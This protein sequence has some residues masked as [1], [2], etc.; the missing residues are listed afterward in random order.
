ML[1]FEQS[2]SV[3]P[4]C[5]II[6]GKYN[7]KVISID[8]D[9][10]EPDYVTS[11]K[12]LEIGN[13]SKLQMVPNTSS[14]RDVYY[15]TGPSGSG[16]SYFVRMYCEQYKKKFKNNEIYL[17]SNLKEDESLDS[18]KPKRVKLDDDLYN[19]PIKVDEF[20]DSCVIFDDTDC[21]S[22]KKIRNAVIAL[23]DQCLEVGRHFR[24]TVLIT[25]HLPSDRQA[26]RKMLN[27]CGYLVYFPQSS[28][29]K[30]K[31]VLTNYL[32]IEEKMIKYFKRLNSRWICIRKN[33]P[34]CWVSEHACALLNV[35][36][37]DE[38]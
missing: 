6:G 28:S 26:T 36:S 20:A 14:E 8:T 29:S 18:V 16:K 23:L 19:D 12:K 9:I 31:Y 15:I 11:F 25:F 32:D 4:L 22:D 2:K 13:S 1:T 37:E 33:F 38:K 30:I 35:D 3:K 21:I 27:E 34:M 24:I 17:F 7:N 5:K 10:T